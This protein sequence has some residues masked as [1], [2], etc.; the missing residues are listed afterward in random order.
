MSIRHDRRTFLKGTFG[1]AAVGLLAAC[2][3]STT[4]PPSTGSAA[5]TTAPAAAKGVTKVSY[6]FASYNGLHLVATV[7]SEKPD[8]PRKFGIELDLVTT[9]NSPNAVNA[10]IGGSVDVAGATPDSAWPAQDKAPDI[11]QVITL[12]DGTPYVLIA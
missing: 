11:K 9:T 8:L 2:A 12:A 1:V 3:P 10:L 6:A 5:A 7:A 4:T